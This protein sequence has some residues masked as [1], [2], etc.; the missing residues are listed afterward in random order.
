[1]RFILAPGVDGKTMELFA[2]EVDDKTMDLFAPRVDGK[3]MEL[4]APGVDG[5]T[6]E[7]FR[8]RFVFNIFNIG[9]GVKCVFNIT[10]FSLLL[11]SK[12]VVFLSA[13]LLC[14]F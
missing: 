10:T 4:F 8:A 13:T 1:M 11:S 3:T 14:N 5:E 12:D 2:P 9:F 6:M 7:L